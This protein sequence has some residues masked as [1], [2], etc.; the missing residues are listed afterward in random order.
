M[1]ALALSGDWASEFLPGAD[2]AA[3]ASAPGQ[4]GLGEGADADWTK[5]FISEV[6]GENKKKFYLFHGG[7]HHPR[8]SLAS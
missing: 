7:L 2:A 6:S 8:L 5:E 4:V 3:A 1:A